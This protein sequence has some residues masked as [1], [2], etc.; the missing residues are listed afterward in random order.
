MSEQ[1]PLEPPRPA[2]PPRSGCLTAFMVLLGIVLLLPG[3]CAL[4][5]TGTILI[6]DPRSLFSDAGGTISLW[7][8]CFG[9]SALGIILLRSA[10]RSGR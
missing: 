2:V 6:Q 10:M 7:V 4:I 9:I 5:L 8:Y 3:L 1:P